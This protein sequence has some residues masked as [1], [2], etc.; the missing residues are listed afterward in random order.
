[1]LLS[2]VLNEIYDFKSNLNHL[3]DMSNYNTFAFNKNG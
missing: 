3:F 2:D 1:M